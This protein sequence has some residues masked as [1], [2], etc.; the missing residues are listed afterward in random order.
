V[1][2]PIQSHTYL[3]TYTHTY[4]I[5][6]LCMGGKRDWGTLVL[7][8]LTASLRLFLYWTLRRKVCRKTAY[9]GIHEISIFGVSCERRFKPEKK[10]HSLYRGKT[11][12]PTKAASTVKPTIYF[13]ADDSSFELLTQERTNDDLYTTA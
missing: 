4:T 8:L 1:Y 13:R 10:S 6:T 2:I 12:E 7:L 5:K 11:C 3:H 9:I